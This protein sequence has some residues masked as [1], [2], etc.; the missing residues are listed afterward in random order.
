MA[1]QNKSLKG[2]MLRRQPQ[3]IDTGM[4]VQCQ[5]H[6]PRQTIALCGKGKGLK[7]VQ[8]AALC[9]ALLS[10]QVPSDVSPD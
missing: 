5:K 6:P 10:L 4:L 9:W 2:S 7:V 1:F 3:R 8:A